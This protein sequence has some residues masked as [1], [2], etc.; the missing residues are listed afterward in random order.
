MEQPLSR[1]QE[2]VCSRCQHSFNSWGLKRDKCLVCDPI[3]PDLAKLYKAQIDRS[4]P[5]VRL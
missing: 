1:K 4:D 5:L 3:R 2:K